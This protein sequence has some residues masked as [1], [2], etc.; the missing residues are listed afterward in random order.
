[1]PIDEA[2]LGYTNRRYE[3]ALRKAARIALP[4]GLT[5]KIITAPVFLATE[6]ATCHDMPALM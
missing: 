4:S 3:S 1:M 2:V 6:M 5:I